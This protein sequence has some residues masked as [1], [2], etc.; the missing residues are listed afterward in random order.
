MFSKHAPFHS[1][2][3]RKRCQTAKSHNSPG[4]HI[5]FFTHCCRRVK[6]LISNM[7]MF[8]SFFYHR[9]LCLR[10]A[11]GTLSFNLSY[12]V[13]NC[14]TCTELQL[15]S[16]TANFCHQHFK[17]IHFKALWYFCNV[18]AMDEISHFTLVRCLPP[19]AHNCLLL[20]HTQAHDCGWDIQLMISITLKCLK[21]LVKDEKL[22]HVAQ[23]FHE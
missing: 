13:K 9:G 14:E 5:L 4:I 19:R 6:Y 16:L 10:Y 21:A 7:R 23:V 11:W 8:S 2:L 1:A 12:N 20:G 22:G 15:R 3:K 18:T 17:L